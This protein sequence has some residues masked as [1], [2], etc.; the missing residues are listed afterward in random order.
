MTAATS[1]GCRLE[2]TLRRQIDAHALEHGQ[3][4]LRGVGQICVAWSSVPAQADHNQAVADDWLDPHVLHAGERS[5]MAAVW[6]GA[7]P[8]R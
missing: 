5:W 4:R 1:L 8:R 2:A 6:R 7:T 3:Q